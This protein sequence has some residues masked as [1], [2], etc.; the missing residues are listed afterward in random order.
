MEKFSVTSY[1]TEC[2][3]NNIDSDGNF[4]WGGCIEKL[5]V[6]IQM[7]GTDTKLGE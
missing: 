6:K 4:N 3:H 2:K 1:Q 7:M 5:F